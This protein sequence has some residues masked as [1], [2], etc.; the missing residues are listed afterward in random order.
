MLKKLQ[1][2]VSRKLR[3]IRESGF[4]ECFRYYYEI[5]IKPKYY[6]KYHKIPQFPP[7]VHIET[8]SNCNLKCEMCPRNILTRKD[9]V[10][11]MG[12]YKK[13]VDELAEHKQTFIISLF[14][15]GEP[16]LDKDIFERIKYAKDKGI[17]F[18]RINTNAMLLD[19]EKSK[20]LLESGLD[21]ITFAV[22]ATKE[23]HEKMRLGANYDKVV[24]SIKRFMA[25]K[26]QGK[27]KK[28]VVQL[29]MLETK[30]TK[31][32]VLKA[33]NFWTKIVDVAQIQHIDSIAGQMDVERIVGKKKNRVCNQ[34][35]ATLI[36]LWNGD[37]TVCCADHDGKLKIGNVTKQSISE[38][39]Q[40]AKF[41]SLCKAHFSEDLEKLPQLCKQCL[42]SQY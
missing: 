29:Q 24:N 40:S 37:V 8:T 35:G 7:I 12:L 38:L 30:Q 3:K 2:N 19:D 1:Q 13:I 14:F 16:L 41:R 27:Y 11:D 42:T 33:Y 21:N 26:K 22:E 28:P 23:L 17:F 5:G 4:K 15:S 10:M 36:F 39:W 34:I 6:I 31:N 32:E 25:L 20:K 9:G 18:V